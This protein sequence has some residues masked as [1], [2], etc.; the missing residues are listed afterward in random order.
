VVIVPFTSP[1]LSH[2]KPSLASSSLGRR[3]RIIVGVPIGLIRYR[4]VSP[5]LEL[6]SETMA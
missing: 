4:V 6:F 3:E 1:P 2:V 5:R